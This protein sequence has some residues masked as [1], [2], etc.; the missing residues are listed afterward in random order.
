MPATNLSKSIA[1]LCASLALGL[2]AAS[3]TPAFAAD[4]LVK[5]VP[6]PDLSK[7]PTLKQKELRD[8][9]FQFEKDKPSL[10]GDDLASAH[11]ELG[12]TY[13]RAGFYD[14]AA[15][16]LEDA[17]ALAPNDARWIYAHG[18]VAR[19]QKQDAAAIDDFQRAFAI[20]KAYLPIRIA[21]ANANIEKGDLEAARKL[22]ADYTASNTKDAVAFALQGEIALREKRYPEA[23]DATKRA[24]A[25]DPKATKL[26]AQ[27][28]E[29]YTGA[30]D[31]KAAADAR[32]KAGTGVPALGDPILIGLLQSTGNSDAPAP[33]SGDAK[34]PAPPADPMASARIL[35]GARNYDGVRKNLDDVLRAK[36]GDV[37]ALLMYA[38]ADA[39]SGNVAHAQTQARAAVAA[40]PNSAGAQL[41]LGGVLEMANDDRGAQA[42]YEKSASLAPKA[43]EPLIA[44]GNMQMRGHHDAEAATQ[45]RAALKADPTSAEAWSRIVAAQ[46]A[47]GD[48]VGAIKDV[49]SALAKDSHNGIL[50]EL[51]IRSAST[52]PGASAEEKR[53]ALDYGKDIYRQND[54]AAI[55]EAYALALAA[56]GKWDDAVKT[57]QAA[58]FLLVRNGRR[59]IVPAYRET[60]QQFQAKKVPT[61]PWAPSGELMQPKRPAPDAAPAPPK[62]NGRPPGAK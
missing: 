58:M 9:R 60:L 16:A 59:E 17:A 57:Q 54:T 10:V 5:T 13:A 37:E 34:K 49:N 53:M 18:L 39:A 56:N 45:Y 61:T 7:L 38:R 43:A 25:V 51:F 29:A 32:A 36:P 19:M 31:A 55:G 22:M 62:P 8:A 40:N 23:I 42:A 28:A 41:V 11:A 20:D 26:Y 44:L 27:L 3:V 21:L 52:C 46:T 30:G 1:A 4:P 48:C 50:M 47:G 12:A 2:G 6:M 35:M 33:E 24:L 14:A 15:V